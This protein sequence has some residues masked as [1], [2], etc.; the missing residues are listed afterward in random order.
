MS[1]FGLS[2]V[3]SGALH[4]AIKDKA[5]HGLQDD[6]GCGGREAVQGAD[7]FINQRFGFGLGVGDGSTGENEV[8]DAFDLVGIAALEQ[9]A[10]KLAVLAGGGCHE[11]DHGEG[12]LALLDVDAEGFAHGLFVADDVED[13]VL[14]LECGAQSESKL[15]HLLDDS[16]ARSGEA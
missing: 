8:S 16:F 4:G 3:I 5:G 9:G 6:L 13:V 10:E 15:A 11:M 1:V 2:Q 12:E 7:R 14:N